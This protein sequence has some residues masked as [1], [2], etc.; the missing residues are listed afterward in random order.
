MSELDATKVDVLYGF[1]RLDTVW[2]KL[3]D[4]SVQRGCHVRRYD[5]RPSEPEHLAS[6][7]IDW[8]MIL[9]AEFAHFALGSLREG[10]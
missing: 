9:P 2:R 10:G 8:G 4:G 7:K 1:V 3:P 6:E 5:N